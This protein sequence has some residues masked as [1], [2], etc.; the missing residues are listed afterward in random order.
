MAEVGRAV[1]APADDLRGLARLAEDESIDLVVVGPEVPL[2]SGLTDVLAGSGIP[3]FGPTRAAAEIEGSKVY[4]RELARRYDVPM[5]EGSSFDDPDAAI[6]Y[7]RT[8][9]SPI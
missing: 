1:P 7:A 8:I 2:V 6:D 3:V 4:C 9:S 5:A